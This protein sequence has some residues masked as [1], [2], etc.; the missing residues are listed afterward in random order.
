MPNDILS[1]NMFYLPD[2]G[3]YGRGCEQQ[4]PVLH[5]FPAI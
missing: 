5:M 4:K 3:H 2:A 1:L